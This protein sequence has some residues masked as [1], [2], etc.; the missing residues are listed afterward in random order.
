MFHQLMFNVE[1][2][3]SRRITFF[4]TVVVAQV[5]ELVKLKCI[6]TGIH[7][8]LPFLYPHGVLVHGKDIYLKIQ[9]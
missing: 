8:D 4:L 2:F 5:V 6:C 3:T 9:L 7:S 1:S